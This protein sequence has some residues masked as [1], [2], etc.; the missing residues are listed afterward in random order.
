M[1]LTESEN[2]ALVQA[3]KIEARWP[4][5][6]WLALVFGVAMVSIGIIDTKATP[7]TG[8]IFG[9]GIVQLMWVLRLWKGRPMLKLLLKFAD[10]NQE[11]SN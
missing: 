4:K 7:E 11:N 6:R 2:K 1:Q 9:L 5:T 8:I 3:K 10:K